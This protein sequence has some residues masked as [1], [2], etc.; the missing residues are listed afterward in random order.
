MRL[1]LPVLGD[2]TGMWP[3][4]FGPRRLGE[5]VPYR[6]RELLQYDWEDHMVYYDQQVTWYLDDSGFTV[7]Q[8]IGPT[9]APLCM[10]AFVNQ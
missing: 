4:C 10:V 6:V 9:S 7:G 2:M 3:S 1:P 5:L 8:F